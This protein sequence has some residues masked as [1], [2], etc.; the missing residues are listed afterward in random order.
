[1][2]YD[3]ILFKDVTIVHSIIRGRFSNEHR[4]PHGNGEKL[5]RYN[6]I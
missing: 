3:E 4:L 5:H 1:M 2:S 6:F